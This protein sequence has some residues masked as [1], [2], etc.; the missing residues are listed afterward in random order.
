LHDGGL[1][2]L[3]HSG[4][5]LDNGANDGWDEESDEGWDKESDEG[6]D[7]ESDEGWDEESD[8][9]SDEDNSWP[10]PKPTLQNSQDNTISSI[11]ASS[12]PHREHRIRAAVVNLTGSDK[13]HLDPLVLA[14]PP[15]PWSVLETHGPPEQQYPSHGSQETLASIGHTRLTKRHVAGMQDMIT[16]LAIKNTRVKSELVA[17]TNARPDPILKSRNPF[18]KSRASTSKSNGPHGVMQ[19]VFAEQ[20]GPVIPTATAG[21]GKKIVNAMPKFCDARALK[22]VPGSHNSTS[23]MLKSLPTSNPHPPETSRPIEKISKHITKPLRP[24]TSYP[25]PPCPIEHLLLEPQLSM[26]RKKEIETGPALPRPRARKDESDEE[27]GDA[28]ETPRKRTR[29]DHDITNTRRKGKGREGTATHASTAFPSTN[30]SHTP[31]T[32]TSVQKDQKA[33]AKPLRP[34]T[35]YPVPPCPIEHLLLVPQLSLKK[36]KGI[37]TELAF[38]RSMDESDDSSEGKASNSKGDGKP[39]KKIG[40][41]HGAT[42]TGKKS[43]QK[44]SAFDWNKWRRTTI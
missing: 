2:D 15:P 42:N 8:E 34:I 17:N 16:S 29:L 23:K 12:L 10:E 22:I 44:G 30:N 38:P 36:K 20:K 21:P 13:Y 39:P 31:E 1:K 4:D 25:V 27:T 28:S 19:S 32:S 6:W 18:L 5:N 7:E 9:G 14:R 3:R 41:Y 33:P 40:R 26:K 11:Y 37:Q 43:K 35:S 24:I